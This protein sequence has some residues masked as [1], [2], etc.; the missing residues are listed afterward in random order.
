MDFGYTPEQEA[1]RRGVRQFIAEN[2]TSDVV[3]E[4]EGQESGAGNGRRGRGPLVSELFERIGEK[5]LARHQL[6]QGVRRAGWGPHKPV[7]R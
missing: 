4:M 6:A 7:H 1:L 2:V 5:R 3:E